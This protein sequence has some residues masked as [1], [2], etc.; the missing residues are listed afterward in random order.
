MQTPRRRIRPRRGL[1][2]ASIIVL[3]V[4]S[5]ALARFYTDVLW[6][7]EVGFSSVLWK[8]L[9]T[10]FELGLGAG[11]L[12][13]LVVWVNL[14]L[15]QRV[16]PAYRAEVAGRPDPLDRYREAFGPFV[17]WIRVG[18]ALF[19]GLSVGLSAVTGWQTLLLWAN[20]VA[21][22]QTDPQFGKDIS[23][24]VFDLPFYTQMLELV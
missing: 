22:G 14:W 23:F 17:S 8:S 4:A 6:F 1:I 7:Q 5:G 2:I 21:F 13:A 20:K 16:A 9:S 10:Q 11:V 3:F 19:A 15:A 18:V 12:A 24:Y